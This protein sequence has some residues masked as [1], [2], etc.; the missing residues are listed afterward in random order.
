M[1]P[2]PPPP[3]PSADGQDHPD[4]FDPDASH[5]VTAPVAGLA[6]DLRE[7]NKVSRFVQDLYGGRDHPDPLLHRRRFWFLTIC[8]L[9]AASPLVVTLLG[10]PGETTSDDNPATRILSPTTEA[11]NPAGP[12]SDTDRFGVARSES[13][14]IIDLRSDPLTPESA[15]PESAG[16]ESAESAPAEPQPLATF[17]T[18]VPLPTT[19]TTTAPPETQLPPESAPGAQVVETTLQFHPYTTVLGGS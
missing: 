6:P 14:L 1:I 10:L 11:M 8:F 9:F 18:V 13:P 16:L 2:E 7:P 15:G 12:Q 17:P 5:L 19:T 4:L 3:G